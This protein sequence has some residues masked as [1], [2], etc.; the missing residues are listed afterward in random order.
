MNHDKDWNQLWIQ[1]GW[2]VN[3]TLCRYP[4]EF[5]WNLHAPKGHLPLFNQLRG[6]R[7][8]QYLFDHPAWNKF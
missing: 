3:N 8:L 5:T 2:K 1:L 6:V 7:S 4:S